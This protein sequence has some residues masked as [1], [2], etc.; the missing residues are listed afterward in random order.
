VIPIEDEND[1][2]DN[3]SRFHLHRDRSKTK[4]VK[5]PAPLLGVRK[6]NG[7]PED[8]NPLSLNARHMAKVPPQGLPSVRVVQ[9]LAFLRSLIGQ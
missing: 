6:N 5:L 2:E 3:S 8:N 7:K 1:S 4:I 9:K